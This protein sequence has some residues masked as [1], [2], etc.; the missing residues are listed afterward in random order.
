MKLTTKLKVFKLKI[1]IGV[2]LLLV[3]AL[4]LAVFGVYFKIQGLT[5]FVTQEQQAASVAAQADNLGGIDRKLDALVESNSA[6]REELVGI[7]QELCL[8][9]TRGDE[10]ACGI[11]PE[12]QVAD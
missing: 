6:L 5:A 8:E 7:R 11:E 10:R 12:P 1:I 3:I 9:R 4:G 2:T